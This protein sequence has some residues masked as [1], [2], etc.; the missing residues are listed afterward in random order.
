LPRQRKKQCLSRREEGARWQEVWNAACT[1]NKLEK[2]ITIGGNAE[3]LLSIP[4]NLGQLAVK[5]G[6]Y[7]RHHRNRGSWGPR[8]VSV[9][10][11]NPSGKGFP[12]SSVWDK[13][14]IQR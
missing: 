5:S 11:E 8:V 12:K 7:R 3:Q 4:G 9:K 2:R 14:V 6:F 10:L 1:L 13:I